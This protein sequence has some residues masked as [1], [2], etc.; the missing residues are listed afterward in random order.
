MIEFYRVYDALDREFR[1]LG[2]AVRG[3]DDLPLPGEPYMSM[4]DAKEKSAMVINQ[5]LGQ[6]VRAIQMERISV[7]LIATG[8]IVAAVTSILYF[9][10][11]PILDRTAIAWTI[12][13]G[14]IGAGLAGLGMALNSIWKS[15]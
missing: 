11:L 10:D 1:G 8:L 9:L 13:V 2:R 3:K 6:E 15:Q 4:H 14:L 7:S 5:L 12:V